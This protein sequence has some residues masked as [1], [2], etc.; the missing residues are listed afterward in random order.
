VGQKLQQVS[1]EFTGGCLHDVS[2]QAQGVIAEDTALWLH[3]GIA[4]VIGLISY[5]LWAC[6]KALQENHRICKQCLQGSV[7]DI[8]TLDY[9]DEVGLVC[10][11]AGRPT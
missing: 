1:R 8:K 2:L 7:I 4:L 9:I 10:I 11:F 6:K 5:E 3:A